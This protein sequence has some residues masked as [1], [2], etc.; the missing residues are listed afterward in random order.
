MQ[1]CVTEWGG[2]P[3][4]AAITVGTTRVSLRGLKETSLAVIRSL[5]DGEARSTVEIAARSGLPVKTVYHAVNR[6]WY[7]HR[8]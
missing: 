1:S 4:G 5:A 6:L 8:L 3:D 2:E 7:T